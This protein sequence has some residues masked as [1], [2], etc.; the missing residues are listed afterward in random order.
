MTETEYLHPAPNNWKIHEI[1]KELFGRTK[2]IPNWRLADKTRRCLIDVAHTCSQRMPDLEGK[3][4]KSLGSDLSRRGAISGLAIVMTRSH[5][6]AMSLIST[7][8]LPEALG[9]MRRGLES[10]LLARSI[11]DDESGQKALRWMQFGSG[12]NLTK[13]ASK[14]GYRKHLDFLSTFAHADPRG[15]YS[16]EVPGHGE[17]E[18]D[19]E[20]LRVRDASIDPAPARSDEQAGLLL[21]II[22]DESLSMAVAVAEV[23]DVGIQVPRWIAAE[24][25]K[26]AVPKNPSP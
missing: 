25:K 16:L 17:R 21:R 13:L 4:A 7:G 20:V 6:A 2:N 24:L 19:N 8:Y 10:L 9:N 22:A 18:P 5:G 1:E 3:D 14:Y 11:L 15:L 12:G 26:P 23:F